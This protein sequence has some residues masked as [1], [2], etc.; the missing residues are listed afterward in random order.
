LCA[1]AESAF[2]ALDPNGNITIKWDIRGWTSDGYVVRF[3]FMP[4]FE[5]ANGKLSQIVDFELANGL[6]TDCDGDFVGDGDDV[7][8]AGVPAH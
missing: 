6:V 7:Q 5:L 2:D 8:L 4:D 3:A 1:H